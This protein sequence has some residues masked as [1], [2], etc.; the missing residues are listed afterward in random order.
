MKSEFIGR[1]IKIIK[2]SNKSVIGKI[3]VVVDETENMIS[4]EKDGKEI[5]VIKG[6]CVFEI[7]GKTI[8][9]KEVAKN[10][11]RE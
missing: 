11:K 5:R 9:G 1:K 3:G 6:Q 8:Q 2:S 10:L 4:I 7:D